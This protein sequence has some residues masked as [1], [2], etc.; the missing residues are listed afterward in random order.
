MVVID[1][2]ETCQKPVSETWNLNGSSRFND[3]I[4]QCTVTPVLKLL[5]DVE[6]ILDIMRLMPHLSELAT[7]R[8][9]GIIDPHVNNGI[10]NFGVY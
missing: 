9:I 10:T 4:L 3:D 6:N 2:D 8:V 1:C 5:Y 7:S